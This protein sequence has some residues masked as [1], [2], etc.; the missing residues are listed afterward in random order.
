MHVVVHNCISTNTLPSQNLPFLLSRPFIFSKN[1]PYEE[2]CFHPTLTPLPLKT[3]RF[4]GGV[5]TAS[6]SFSSP[7]LESPVVVLQAPRASP[8]KEAHDALLPLLDRRVV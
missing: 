4:V 2:N 3:E 6:P 1:S 8:D 5:K 7:P